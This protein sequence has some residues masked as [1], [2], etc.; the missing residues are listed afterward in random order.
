MNVMAIGDLNGDFTYVDRLPE[1]V[2]N[3]DIEGVVFAGNILAGARGQRD[4]ARSFSRF[5]GALGSLKVPAFVVPGKN[6]APERFF[7]QAAFNAEVVDAGVYMVHRSFAPLG[8]NY[9]VSGCGGEIT[10]GKRDNESFLMYPAWE[11]QFSLDFL[12]HVKQ[13]KL[14]IFHNAPEEQFDDAAPAKGH[15]AISQMIK[16]Y[17]PRFAVCCRGGGPKGKLVLGSTLVVCPGPLS[18]GYYAVLDILERKAV[19]G[20]LR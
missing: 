9:L 2:K 11:A 13:E 3:A 18:D 7:L 4:E 14:L 19:F 8:R 12:R 20:D 16:N 15:Q 1:V 10:D 17:S 6:D 5:F